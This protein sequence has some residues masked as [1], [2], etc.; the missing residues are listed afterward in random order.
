VSTYFT[1]VY[2]GLTPEQIVN[3]MS[4][5][6]CRYA[7]HGHVADERDAALRE[8]A[9]LAMEVGYAA[10]RED[11]LRKKLERNQVD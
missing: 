1:V 11:T 10:M 4:D 2:R 9:R 7:A 6:Q 3:I 5:P 8:V